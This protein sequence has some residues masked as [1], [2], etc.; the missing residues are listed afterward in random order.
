MGRVRWP[1]PTVAIGTLSPPAPFLTVEVPVNHAGQRKRFPG[2]RL[3]ARLRCFEAT[4]TPAMRAVESDPTWCR[5]STNSTGCPNWP[6]C[7]CAAD[8][9]ADNISNN[10]WCHGGATSTGGSGAAPSCAQ[11][12]VPWISVIVCFVVPLAFKTATRTL[13]VSVG[14]V[15]IGPITTF[16]RPRKKENVELFACWCKLKKARSGQS[17]ASR[18]LSGVFFVLP[19]WIGVFF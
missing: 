15:I 7:S 2:A 1:A 3:I 9:S 4:R 8:N 17:S 12:P 5:Y 13:V 19:H 10:S 14:T 11:S 6:A 16:R 18:I